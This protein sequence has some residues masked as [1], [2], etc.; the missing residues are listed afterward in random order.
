[1]GKTTKNRLKWVDGLR[2]LAIVLVVAH[3]AAQA[4]GPTGG[5]W[6]VSE[7]ERSLLLGPFFAVNA[8]F[9][10]GLFFLLAGYFV[11]GSLTRKKFTKFVYDRLVRLGVPLIVVGFGIF[12]LIGWAANKGDLSF[13]SYYFGTYLGNWE[14]QFAHLWFV[15][16]LLA[17]SLI[18]AILAQAFPVLA[19]PGKSSAPKDI[20]LICLVLT[21][22][23]VGG[24]V[25]TFF[26]QDIWVNVLWVFP[27]EPAHL[28]QYVTMFILGTLAGRHGWFESMSKSLGVRWFRIGIAAALLWYLLR[29]LADFGDIKL[30]NDYWL[31]LLFP[32]WEAVLCVGLC[33]GLVVHAREHWKGLTSWWSMLAR[34]TYGVYV[35][36]VFVIV[37]LNQALL[38]QTWGP[39]TKFILVTVTTLLL[40]FPLV[41]AVRRVPGLAKVL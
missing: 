5:D 3:H 19:V 33:T 29:Y 34:A 28:P 16:H 23:V 14:V 6:P 18:Y 22:A 32:L 8:G 12:A 39:F 21:L 24:F 15:C 41:L 4:Y 20:K 27:T 7:P 26:Q 1:M 25:R 40:T 2:L 37:G 13:L 30:V 9:F 38:G 10:M 36:H 31:G 35:L 11:P 17:Y